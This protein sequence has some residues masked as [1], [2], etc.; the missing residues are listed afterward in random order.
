MSFNLF[1][2]DSFILDQIIIG[3]KKSKNNNSPIDF[4]DDIQTP[5]K[6]RKVPTMKTIN[7]STAYPSSPNIENGCGIG[8][9]GSGFGQD[10]SQSTHEH[11]G[12]FAC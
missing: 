6:N 1:M 5:P 8:F 9:G 10:A 4:L 7:I 11:A 12:V 3:L 2:V